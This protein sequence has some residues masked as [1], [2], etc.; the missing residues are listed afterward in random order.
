MNL[1]DGFIFISWLLIQ[2]PVPAGQKLCF[3]FCIS[4][5]VSVLLLSRCVSAPIYCAVWHWDWDSADH[6]SRLPSW[7]LLDSLHRGCCGKTETWGQEDSLSAHAHQQQPIFYLP[8]KQ[9]VPAPNFFFFSVIPR[10]RLLQR[11]RH[12]HAA[13]PPKM[14]GSH[15]HRV[16]LASF[17]VLITHPLL[18]ISP[19]IRVVTAS[20][21]HYFY[22]FGVTFSCIFTPPI[23][24]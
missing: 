11:Y 22:L 9:L 4:G 13:C 12:Q 15:L 24:V 10:V 8:Q 17:W 23:S 14:P 1:G 7:L 6:S 18:F 20:C 5:R 21:C 2:A 3:S 19:A 16:T